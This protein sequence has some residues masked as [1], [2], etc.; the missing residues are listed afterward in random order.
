MWFGH[1][2]PV[3]S[4]LSSVPLTTSAD[5]YLVSLD[6]ASVFRLIRCLTQSNGTYLPKIC[7]LDHNAVER[8]SKI[9]RK[10][11]K[12][13]G[14]G[15]TASTGISSPKPWWGTIGKLVHCCSESTPRLATS[16]YQKQFSHQSSQ[17]KE[18]GIITWRSTTRVHGKGRRTRRILNISRSSPFL[19]TDGVDG[20]KSGKKN[21]ISK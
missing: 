20:E 12:V 8:A 19:Q 11:V 6:R 2:I 4:R 13:A 18:V 3:P 17:M 9:W 14:Q 10:W 7:H 16:Y 5:T 21:E 15:E 1:T